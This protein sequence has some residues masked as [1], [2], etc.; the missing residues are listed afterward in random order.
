MADQSGGEGWWLASDGKWYAPEQQPAAPAP[1]TPEVTGSNNEGNSTP[2]W[3]RG[4][5]AWAVLGGG[6]LIVLGVILGVAFGGGDDEDPEPVAVAQPLEAP[7]ATPEPTATAEPTATPEPTATAEPTVTPELLRRVAW[8]KR[9]EPLWAFYI[10]TNGRVNTVLGAGDTR[11]VQATCKTLLGESAAFADSLRWTSDNAPGRIAEY[12]E[13][14]HIALFDG[15]LMCSQGEFSRAGDAML[16]AG[17]S[18]AGAQALL[19]QW[20]REYEAA[21]A[22]L[23]GS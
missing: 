20:T 6:A 3:F 7:T 2:G 15:L 11:T 18:A 16:L 8:L 9:A 22:E 12:W 1:P 13:P 4:W 14:I 10:E 23:G 17:Q 5:M 19:D 21:T